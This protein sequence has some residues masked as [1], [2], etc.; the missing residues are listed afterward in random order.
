MSN[1]NKNRNKK[2]TKDNKV[3]VVR[4][5][6]EV[7]KDLPMQQYLK[8]IKFV[9]QEVIERSKEIE[10][11]H[12]KQFEMISKALDRNITAAMILRTDYTLEEINKI[13]QLAWELIEEDN[14][15]VINLKKEGDG[16]WMKAAEKYVEDI[17]KRSAELIRQG[18]KQKNAIE[19]L[20]NEFP[21]LSKS[22]VTNSYKKS[23]EIMLESKKLKEEIEEDLDALELYHAIWGKEEIENKEVEE[24]KKENIE[25]DKAPEGANLKI[26]SK[27]LIMDIQGEYGTYHIEN[28]K[29]QLEETEFN[30]KED[31]E[32]TYRKHIEYLTK[33]KN[34]ALAIYDMIENLV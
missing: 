9:E 8:V 31:V 19:I 15:K 21:K 1:K 14:K 33:T 6:Q 28:S 17:Q 10:K 23:K 22:M 18:V 7:L 4:K 30:S 2:K 13:F 32:E 34:E 27:S 5:F 16:D 24:M 3:E 25:I 12:D 11:E 20:T 26:L 29:V